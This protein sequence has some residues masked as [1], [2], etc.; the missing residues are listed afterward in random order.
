MELKKRK[1]KA[2]LID[3]DKNLTSQSRWIWVGKEKEGGNDNIF[4]QK[5]LWTITIRILYGGL[6]E[7]D[8]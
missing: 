7:E 6:R 2:T 3:I 8:K 1:L 4:E 5:K